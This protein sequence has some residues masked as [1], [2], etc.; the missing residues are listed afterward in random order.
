VLLFVS[1]SLLFVLLFCFFVVAA[2]IASAAAVADGHGDIFICRYVT[3]S[4]YVKTWDRCY[5]F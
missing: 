5:D 2:A 4:N 3:E 1:F